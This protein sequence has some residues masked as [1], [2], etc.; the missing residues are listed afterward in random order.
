MIMKVVKDKQD[1]RQQKSLYQVIVE[2]SIDFDP[3]DWKEK[4][5]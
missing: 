2:Q 5:K 4:G 3:D 1:K